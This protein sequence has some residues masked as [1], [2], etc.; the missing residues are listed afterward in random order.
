MTRTPFPSA[1]Y[2]DSW[3]NGPFAVLYP[4][5]HLETHLG[6]V[7]LPPG[8]TF[9]LLYLHC[10]PDPLVG[11]RIGGQRHD[12]GQMQEWTQ[13]DGWLPTFPPLSARA[14]YVGTVLMDTLPA[15]YQFVDEKTGE[16]VERTRTYAPLNGLSEW[17]MIGDLQIG[18]LHDGDPGLGCFDGTTLRLI[19]PGLCTF[20]VEHRDGERVTLSFVKPTQAVRIDCGLAE[21]RALPPVEVPEPEPP[22]FVPVSVGDPLPADGRVYDLLP[23]VLGNPGRWPRRG[24]THTLGQI[25]RD[26][27]FYFVK[28]AGNEPGAANGESY[29]AWAYDANW[30]YLLEDASS[31]DTYSFTDPRMWPRFLP[32]GFAAAFDTGPHEAVWRDRTTCVVTKRE[33]FARR[34]WLHGLQSWDWGPDLGV[35]LTAMLVYDDTG[36]FH[37][38]GRY[39]EVGYYAKGAGSVRWES[40]K[41]DVVYATNPPSFP[42]AARVAQSSFYLVGGPNPQPKLLNCVAQTVPSYPPWLPK[43]PDPDPPNPPIP[44]EDE[45]FA[46]GPIVPGFKPGT[47]HDNGNGTVSVQKPNGKWLCVTPNGVIEERDTPGGAWESFHRSGNSLVAVRDGGAAGTLVYVFPVS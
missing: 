21:L 26:Q 17:S 42:A 15:G 31:G 3:P 14:V 13:R 7:A 27:L 38:P 40:Y 37:T 19:E 25:V 12:D 45:M 9:G 35:R 32:I 44:V 4:G 5:S 29:E 43:P 30:L 46:Y 8:E 16:P 11:F 1:T 36:G 24:P 33:P 20:H 22:P 18:Q 23:F 34:M 6:R 41:S 2:L 10:T 39:V 28:F 47:D